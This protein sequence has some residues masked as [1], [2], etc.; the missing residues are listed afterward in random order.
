MKPFPDPTVVN[1]QQHAANIDMAVATI[2]DLLKIGATFYPPLG[3]AAPAISMFINFEAHK[4]KSGLANGSVLPDG[5]GGFVS[6]EWA[7]DPRHAL[8]P[9]GSFK[10]P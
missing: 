10:V 7:A 4:L 8:N 2:L 1:V 9:D 3:V 5:Q 6:K